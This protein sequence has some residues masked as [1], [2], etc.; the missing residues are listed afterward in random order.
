MNTRVR[1]CHT[2]IVINIHL[3]HLHHQNDILV[4]LILFSCDFGEQGEEI[5]ISVLVFREVGGAG[6]LLYRTT[7]ELSLIFSPTPPISCLLLS[8]LFFF[9]VF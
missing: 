8:F 7:M 4:L 3:N 9:W 6:F 5:I 2:L 1:V